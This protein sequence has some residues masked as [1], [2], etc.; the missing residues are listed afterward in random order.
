M[1]TKKMNTACLI[2]LLIWNGCSRSQF[3]HKKG[4]EQ[5]PTAPY[6]FSQSADIWG[7]GHFI[8]LERLHYREVLVENIVE[9]KMRNHLVFEKGRRDVTI[10]AIEWVWKEDAEE[11]LNGALDVRTLTLNAKTVKILSPLRVP[12]ADVIV[13]AQVL[14]VG[15]DGLLDITP[16]FQS[17]RPENESGERGQDGERAGSIVLNVEKLINRAVERPVFIARGGRGQ[18]GSLGR[19]GKD[20]ASVT[21]VGGETLIYEEKVNCVSS[22]DYGTLPKNQLL[23]IQDFECYVFQSEGKLVWPENGEDAVAGGPPGNS[24]D[25]G[26]IITNIPLGDSEVTLL[27]GVPGSQTPG[28][29]GGAAGMPQVAKAIVQDHSNVNS[30]GTDLVTRRTYAGQNTSLLKAEIAM[31]KTGEVL[32]LEGG[33]GSW[34]TLGYRRMLQWYAE[35]HY[36]AHSFEL[37]EDIY[38]ESLELSRGDGGLS[39]LVDMNARLQLQKLHSHRDIFLRPAGEVPDVYFYRNNSQVAYDIRK[40]LEVL[41]R[42]RGMLAGQESA[43]TSLMDWAERESARERRNFHNVLEKGQLLEGC[44]ETSFADLFQMNEMQIH[45]LAEEESSKVWESLMNIT[46]GVSIEDDRNLAL[47]SEGRRPEVQQETRKCEKPKEMALEA[48]R[49]YLSLQKKVFWR[50]TPSF[51]ELKEIEREARNILLKH[52]TNAVKSYQYYHLDSW[53]GFFPWSAIVSKADELLKQEEENW[54]ELEAFFW[55]HLEK[56]FQPHISPSETGTLSIRLNPWELEQLRTEGSVYL[57]LLDGD[58][59]YQG[60][61]GVKIQTIGLWVKSEREGEYNLKVAHPG[62]FY[63]H[64]NG[65]TYYG[66]MASPREWGAEGRFEGGGGRWKREKELP[67]LFQG[68]FVNVFNHDAPLHPLPGGLTQLKVTALQ[69]KELFTEVVLDISYR[70]HP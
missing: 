34:V 67:S 5:A 29:K 28:Y 26:E 65:K 24:G 42:V 14:E 18:D 45:S 41:Y 62:R 43:R 56:I 31:G 4:E 38:R 49:A 15:P 40:A 57:N 7:A 22:D 36:L 51:S 25:G 52:Y 68:D 58:K 37:A 30:S 60:R 21:V 61:E 47:W 64:K 9:D 10:N 54:M 16:E 23:Q 8:P 39:R 32:P 3:S 13:N 63:I 2:G 27:P 50:D 69:G 46:K 35:D 70:Y 33:E 48:A 59:L 20:G 66:E 12:G 6:S 55:N 1:M 53:Q 11:N 44:P 17:S 19:N